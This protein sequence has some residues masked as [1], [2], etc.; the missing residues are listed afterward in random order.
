MTSESIFGRRRRRAAGMLAAALA[1]VLVVTGCSSS[2]ADSSGASGSGTPKK[3]GE[4]TVGVVGGS[5]KD[6]LD[7]HKAVTHPDEARVIQLYDGLME[8]DSD[9]KIKPA[10]A[11]SVTP[12]ATSKVW[13]VKLRDGIKFSDGRPVTVADVIATFQRISNPEDP[14]NG[15]AALAALDRNGFVK[16]D[17]R[18]VEFHFSQ[19]IV[20]FKE[21]VSGYSTGIVPADYDPKNPVGAG[22]YM[23]KSFTPGEQSTF[24]RNPNYWRDGQPYI[25][26]VTIVDFPDDTARVNAL[27]SGQ[28]DAIDQ[29]PLGQVKVAQTT[30]GIKILESKTA[31]FIPF[32]MRVDQ[33]PFDD[34]RVR[35]A[36]R[37]IVDRK[38]MVKQVLAGHGE[39]G[40]DLYSRYDPCYAA[41]IPQR[42][43]DIK[44]AKALLKEAGQENLSVDLVTSPV[45]A[46]MVEAAQV[47]A[48]QAKAAGVQINVKKVDP[49]EFYGDNYLK[50][51]FSQDF[52]FTHDYLSQVLAST[53]ATAPYNETHW[54]DPKWDAL[55]TT[56]QQTTDD[57]KRCGLIKQAQQIEY[58]KG[59]YIIWGFPNAIDAYRTSIEGLKPDKSGI[60]LTGYRFR[61]MW[62]NG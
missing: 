10:L 2:G 16:V 22:P 52:F 40:N 17:D 61:A 51:T 41:D 6:S 35:E 48:Q 45:A 32:T 9:L 58:D 54:A 36:F 20:N 4:M 21:Q 38:Q 5:A 50:W 30:P 44:K 47:F 8:Q 19:P 59:G 14:T 33:A 3:G 1:V 49:G 42:K 55:V 46:G 29:L 24:V 60:P 18:T 11:V 26:S 43:Q 39:I 34:P 53:S 31:G 27:L 12:D 57:S 23:L 28:V 7:A 56:A 13:T 37:L 62:I 25:D 15:T